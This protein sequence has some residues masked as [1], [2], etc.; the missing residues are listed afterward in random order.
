[1]PTTSDICIIGGGPAGCVLGARLAQFGLSVC[2]V[3]REAFPR[4]H[5]GESL[6]PGVAPLLASIG[7]GSAI[8]AAGYPRVRKVSLCW[9]AERERQDSDGQGMLVDRGHFDRLLLEHARGCGLRIL[10][11]ATV[12]KLERRAGGWS[13]AVRAEGRMTELEVSLVADASGRAGVLR[14]RRCR[15]GPQTL[16]LHAY[17]TGKGLPD[18]P[19]IEAG[20]AEWFWGVPLPDGIYNTLVFLDPRDLRA[21][22]GTLTTKFHRLIAASS[23]L[24]SGVN[25]RLVGRIHAADATPYLDE[26][27]VTEDSIKVGDAALA[28]DAISSSGV[29]KAIQSALA[30]SAVVNTLLQRPRARDLARQFYRESLSE[31]STRHRAWARGHYAQVAAS[32]TARF[33]RERA[34]AATLP[35]IA[36][37]GAQATVPP[38]AALR[39]SPGVE[40][41]ELPCVVDR[42]IEARPAVRHPSLASPVAYLGEE[43]L[44]PLLRCVRSGMTP[45]DLARS[46][47]P[48]VP[49]PKGLA[50]AQWLVSRG[51]LISQAD[52]RAEIKGSG[53]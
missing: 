20:A 17:W 1:M 13:I 24:P 35:G 28:L 5:L 45:R 44:A 43:E 52:V 29:Q 4:R 42:F 37:L 40:I 26:E 7:A 34:E 16:A 21:M 38:D 49:P 33:W 22:Q 23:L 14:C 36:P 3:E 27:C 30:G 32:R 31:A 12:E 15:T 47:M 25:A 9:E 8:E 41:V 53:A 19:R 2:L 50:I 39:L 11:P 6:S 46:W 18:Q 51:L 10:Q 48:R